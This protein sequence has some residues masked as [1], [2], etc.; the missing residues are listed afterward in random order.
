MMEGR[1]LMGNVGMTRMGM[2]GDRRGL[3]LEDWSMRGGRMSKH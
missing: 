2:E 1:G 3:L